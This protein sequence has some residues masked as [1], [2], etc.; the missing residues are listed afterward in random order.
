MKIAVYSGSFNPL[1]IG[2]MAVVRY[3]LEHGGFDKVYLIVSPHN[4]FK[5]SSLTDTGLERLSAA[6]AAIER[7]GLSDRVL[8]D[9]IE[10]HMSVPSYTIR[11]LDALQE[12]EPSNRFTLVIGGDNLPEMLSWKEGKRIMEQYGVVVYPRDCYDMV[13]DCRILRTKHRNEEVLFGEEKHKPLR[14]K[15]LKDAPLV[16]I[17]S[18]QLRKMAAEGTDTGAYLA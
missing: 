5:D 14:I 7:N 6:R 16:D 1:H 15:L 11:T 17:S 12:R 13:R 3:L 9:D 8:V 18:S 4:P 2:H 10:F